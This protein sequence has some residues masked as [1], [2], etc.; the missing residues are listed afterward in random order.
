MHIVELGELHAE[1][2]EVETG[3]FL[4]EV[5]REHVDAD[6]VLVEVVEQLDLGNH[7]VGERAAHHEARVAG[8]A[9]KVHEAT[10]GQHDHGVAVIE[11]PHVCSGLELVTRGT[12]ASETGDVDLGVEVADVAHDGVVLHVAHVIGRDDGLITGSGDEDV[13]GV[14]Y[15]F[16]SGDLITL[17]GSLQGVDG[18][19]FG[20]DH[21]GTLTLERLR[22]TLANVAVTS[23]DGDLACD[24]DIGSAADGIDERVAAA[25]QVVELRLGDRVVHV[26]GGEDELALF[27]HLVK[28]MHTRGGLLG[29]ALDTSS[30]TGPLGGIFTKGLV[31]QTEHDRK[32]G[33]GGRA[34]I[35]NRAGLFVLDTLVN[36]KRGV[37]AI[38]E[39]HVG[40]ITRGPRHHLLG[41]PPVLLK[42][43]ALPGKHRNALWVL[44]S[45]VRANGHGSSS[46]VLGGENVAAGP[47]HFGTKLDQSLDENSG[48]NGHVERARNA[49]ALE[50]LQRA[51]LFADGAQA[52]HLVLGEVNFLAAKRS[53]GNIG[54]AEVTSGFSGAHKWSSKDTKQR[55]I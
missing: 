36:E 20:D 40:A 45:A 43:L 2:A 7:L 4:V 48:L 34:W 16:D 51:V 14:E 12:R 50:W 11:R 32:L 54:D 44:G 18:V 22:T 26:D 41:A 10:L 42:R 49:G 47:T 13:G 19:D 17:H 25:I 29:D 27:V 33:V 38:V 39:D 37:T 3:D 5:L 23:D 1:G 46:M 15:V 52:G 21:A 24:H 30:H 55:W 53:K 35:R 6:R 9:T 28:A 8:G 31:Q